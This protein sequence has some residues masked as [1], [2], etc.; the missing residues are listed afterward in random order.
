[1]TEKTT[2]FAARLR[3]GLTR[4]GMTQTELAQ[5]SGISKSSISRY[6]KGDWEG[7]QEA[8]YALA[9]AL[10]VNEAWL[11]GYAVAPERSDAEQLYHTTA[12]VVG[13]YRQRRGLSQ[14]EAARQLEIPAAELQAQEAGVRPVPPALLAKMMQL[15]AIPEEALNLAAANELLTD[16][17]RPVQGTTVTFEGAPLTAAQIAELRQFARFLQQRDKNGD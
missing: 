7:K 5:R 8:V 14:E 16:A 4:R 1:M 2:S 10:G 15:Y 6:L 11:M 17:P 9:R 3:E 12:Q 13:A